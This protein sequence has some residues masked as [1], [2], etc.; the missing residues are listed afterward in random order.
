MN[1]F[2][3][4]ITILIVIFSLLALVFIIYQFQKDQSPDDSSA[5]GANFDTCTTD[6]DCND[7]LKCVQ[8]S[9]TG[10][11][12]S[13][14]SLSSLCDRNLK[15]CNSPLKCINNNANENLEYYKCTD[16][17]N[18]SGCN[19]TSDCNEGL[20]CVNP[21]AGYKF[22]SNLLTQN[23][24]DE[25]TK[26]CKEG[27]KC[28]DQDGSQYKNYKCTSGDNK[29]PCSSNDDCKTGLTCV[30]HFLSYSDCTDKNNGSFCDKTN[31][32]CN[33]GLECV[34]ARIEDADPNFLC[35]DGKN[36]SFCNINSDCN[37]GLSC[38]NYLG[39]I[40]ACSDLNE[41]SKCDKN[42]KECNAGLTCT[43]ETNNM[44]KCTKSTITITPTILTS[45]TPSPTPTIINTVCG[46]I[47]TDGNNKLTLLD[48]GAFVKVY[49]Q[50]CTD[51]APTTGCKGKDTN[52]DG[53][54]N[55]I[56]LANFVKRY[57]NDSC[58]IN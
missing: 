56:D 57:E 23:L 4:L 43:A 55:L 21:G 24:C 41:G 9:S 8:Y 42:S 37:T 6:T 28:I 11:A 36:E 26:V 49:G 51:Q 40:L 44:Y 18:Y 7:G 22:C 2:L 14:G 45:S 3:K 31:K 16:G 32:E 46:N 5:A 10:K 20:I 30:N 34:N 54:I 58:V 29:N 15:Q 50:N 47:D 19:N 52:V 33:E 35:T 1:K 48:L 27:L 39:L 17:A 38:V 12:C 53:K 13:N 25:N